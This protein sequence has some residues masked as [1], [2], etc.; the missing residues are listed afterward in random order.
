MD[1]YQI[2]SN[3]FFSAQSWDSREYKTLQV[4]AAIPLVPRGQRWMKN[5][6][7][8]WPEKDYWL[9]WTNS[10]K[11]Q[12]PCPILVK[13]DS[14]YTCTCTCKLSEESDHFNPYTLWIRRLC[15]SSFISNFWGSSLLAVRV[16]ASIWKDLKIYM[17]IKL[18]YENFC[19][20][21]NPPASL[22]IS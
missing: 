19:S 6:F 4:K 7:L 21:Q 22:N 1:R 16:L 12:N 2:A 9:S 15:G 11:A 3:V 18:W 14:G 8:F 5:L 17:D 20:I 10:C 13:S